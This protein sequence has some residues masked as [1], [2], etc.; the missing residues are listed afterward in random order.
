MKQMLNAMMVL[1]AQSFDG[2]YDKGGT[3][4]IMH[5]LAVMHKLRSADEELQCIALGH[6]LIE[7]TKVTYQQ[8]YDLGFSERVVLGIAAM[9][10]Q[11]GQTYE[12]YKSQVKAN[13]DAILVKMSDLQHNSDLRR[14]KGVTAKDVD[15]VAKYMAFYQELKNELAK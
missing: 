14:L 3:P 2:V 10:K 13:K 11:R 6:D 9:T 12:Q 15:R 5:C 1:V 7:D 4:Y 8:L